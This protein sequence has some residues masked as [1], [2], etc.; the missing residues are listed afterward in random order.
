MI[1]INGI[2]PGRLFKGEEQFS[3]VRKL[4]SYKSTNLLLKGYKNRSSSAL[5]R[6]GKKYN[7]ANYDSMKFTKLNN[8]Y[9][10][11]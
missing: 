4:S 5:V 6:G 9:E 8:N 11:F 7:A 3:D 2:A 10:D 1:P